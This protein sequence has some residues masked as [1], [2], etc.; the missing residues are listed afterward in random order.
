MHKTLQSLRH[1]L[2]VSCQAWPG[3]PM[4]D[5]ETLRRMAQS[6][7]LGGAM[8][9]RL[10]S[11]E[12]VLAIRGDS[13]L[14]IIAI[15]KSLR[16]GKLRITPDFESAALLAAAGADIIALDC[17]NSIHAYGEPWRGIV[18][19]IHAELGL[20]VMADIATLREGVNAAE[21]GVDLVGTTLNGYTDETS[22]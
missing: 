9:L 3:E 5:T 8:G 19:R 10:N 4:D 22:G 2:I 17:T 15:Q 1:Q 18:R 11:P 14:P 16:G 7:V 12:H 13:H 6:A 20:L 21:A